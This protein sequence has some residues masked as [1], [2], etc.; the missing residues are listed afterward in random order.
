[1]HAGLASSRRPLACAALL[2]RL[3]PPCA[4]LT[5]PTPT[6]TLQERA[7]GTLERLK[8]HMARVQL[9]KDDPMGQWLLRVQAVQM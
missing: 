2:S 4:S 6:P 5:P 3:H 8:V 1:M 9:A 7:E